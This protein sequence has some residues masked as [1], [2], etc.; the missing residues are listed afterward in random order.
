M[1]V[2]MDVKESPIT[3]SQGRSGNKSIIDETKQK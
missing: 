1:T 3:N 2:K